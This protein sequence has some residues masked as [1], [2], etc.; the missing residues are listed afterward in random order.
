MYARELD[1]YEH[2][3]TIARS[4]PEVQF[5]KPDDDW[6]PV[7]FSD[8]GTGEQAIFPMH[9]HMGDENEKNLLANV[10]LP[11][12]I[13]GTRARTLVVVLSVWSA[14]VASPEELEPIRYV[15]AS[16]RE[17]REERLLIMEYTAE[18]I[19]R[20]AWARIIRHEDRPPEL[21]EWEEMEAKSY[22]GRFV[23]PVVD[24]LKRVEA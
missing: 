4:L 18:G 2:V 8:N 16:Q 14:E 7:A 19:Q 23:D 12:F 13:K 22:G 21:D 5:T 15:P 9:E 1:L 17:N 10:I 11:A 24:A 20:Q 6:L 3:A